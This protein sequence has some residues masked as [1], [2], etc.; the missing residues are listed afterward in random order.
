MGIIQLALTRLVVVNRHSDPLE[1]FDYPAGEDRVTE[2]MRREHHKCQQLLN[3]RIHEFLCGE[4]A[5]R[6]STIFLMYIRTTSDGASGEVRV[7]RNCEHWDGESAEMAEWREGEK[8]VRP[9]SAE[10][11]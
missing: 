5:G 6:S 11:T 7:R 1:V 8:E 10:M 9:T 4:L 2:K 3:Q